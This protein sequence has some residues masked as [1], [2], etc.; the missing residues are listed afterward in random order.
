MFQTQKYD[1]MLHFYYNLKTDI[2]RKQ[3]V[4]NQYAYKAMV[5]IFYLVIAGNKG[6]Y[7][8]R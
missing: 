1:Q 5:S 6:Y 2:K 7:G 4:V 3:L 8:K